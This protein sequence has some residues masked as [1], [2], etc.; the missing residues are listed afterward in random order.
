MTLGFVR[1]ATTFSGG[2][3]NVT[4][5]GR[6]RRDRVG[7]HEGVG[8]DTARPPTGPGPHTSRSALWRQDLRGDGT[9]RLLDAEYLLHPAVDQ[10]GTFVAYPAPP[11]RTRGEM[12]LHLFDLTQ[13]Q[14]RLLVQATVARS[15]VPSWRAAQRILFH[16]EDRQVVEVNPDSGAASR[17]FPGEYPTASPDGSRIAYRH[18]ADIRLAGG[19]GVTVDISPRQRTPRRP[20]QGGMSWS[21][22][23]RLLLVGWSGGTLGYERDFGTLDIRTRELTRITQRYL[24]GIAFY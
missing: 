18:G 5:I 8:R 21:P 20:Y 13:R 15:C 14:S 17:L 11:S 23:G 24:Q 1:R 3:D 12:S 7:C 9:D 6:V 2:W 10:G 22:D 4:A 16:T 19:D